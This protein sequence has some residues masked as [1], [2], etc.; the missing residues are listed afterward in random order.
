MPEDFDPAWEYWEPDPEIA[1]LLVEAE[2]RSGPSVLDRVLVQFRDDNGGGLA[3]IPDGLRIGNPNAGFFREG[4]ES[5]PKPTK[6]KKSSKP[7]GRLRYYSQ[8][9]VGCRDRFTS[10]GA[11]RPFCCVKCLDLFIAK[12]QGRLKSPPKRLKPRSCL[13]PECRRVFRPSHWFRVYCSHPCYVTHAKPG[14]ARVLPDTP[15]EFCRVLFRPDH[16]T[17]RYCGRHCASNAQR[18]TLHKTGCPGCGGPVGLWSGRGKPKIYCSRPCKNKVV[19]HRWRMESSLALEDAQS[20]ILSGATFGS[21]FGRV[22]ESD[23]DVLREWFVREPRLNAYFPR[24]APKVPV[25]TGSGN[26]CPKCGQPLIRD[27]KCELCPSCG[28][29]VGSCS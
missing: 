10:F 20:L 18:L 13:S 27:G 5:P 23:R 9:C 17:D 12:N 29:T 19:N 6:P 28:E 15:C 14:C 2:S 1:E 8:K 7:L 4:R 25:P 16:A 22:A 21:V 3:S 26:V 11:P 24:N